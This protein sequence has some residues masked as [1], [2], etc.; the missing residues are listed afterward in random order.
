MAKAQKSEMNI[1][2]VVQAI[3]VVSAILINIPARAQAIS[4]VP[5]EPAST[6]ASF[7]DWV[8]R[9]QRTTE[10]P[11]RVCEAAQT[12]QV[13][14]Q[15]Q[16]VA[17]MAVGRTKASQPPQ[18]ILV[19][20]ASVAFPSSVHVTTD[21]MDSPG[22]D[23]PWVRCLPGVCVAETA[24]REETL[25][26]WRGASSAAASP[27]RTPRARRWPFL[28]LSAASPR[29]STPYQRSSSEGG[30]IQRGDYCSLRAA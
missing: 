28:S 6:S 19:L 20:P 2:P 24:V 8:V 27:T 30:V 10:R 18:V 3:L 7:G 22:L 9:C 26:H 16:P 11:T 15:S 4:P 21:D 13:R 1:S 12:M 25:K 5:P 23:V 29:L 14:R 17:Q